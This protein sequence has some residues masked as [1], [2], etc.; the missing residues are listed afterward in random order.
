MLCAVLHRPGDDKVY[1]QLLTKRDPTYL[2]Y[3]VM[4]VL[5]GRDQL[6]VSD[7][8]ARPFLDSATF[9]PLLKRLEASGLLSRTRSAADER[10]VVIALNDAGCAMASQAAGIQDEVLCAT[11][12]APGELGTIKQCLGQ[13]DISTLT[14]GR[15]VR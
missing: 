12:C 9:T 14:A 13:A 2:Q 1:R 7:I 3:L 8:G 11:A 10:Q 4:L 15:V 6:T 5:W